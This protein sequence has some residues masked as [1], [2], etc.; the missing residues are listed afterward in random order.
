MKTTITV[1]GAILLLAG[2]ANRPAVPSG[3]PTTVAPIESP[4]ARPSLQSPIAADLQDPQLTV[5]RA[6]DYF[7]EEITGQVLGQVWREH[8]ESS[9]ISNPSGSGLFA[10]ERPFE[11]G[12]AECEYYPGGW[13][14]ASR[15][16]LSRAEQVALIETAFGADGFSIRTIDGRTVFR[17]LCRDNQADCRPA[18]AISAFPHFVLIVPD[19]ASVPLRA[20]AA[21]VIR[22]IDG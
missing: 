11:F 1:V 12:W 3:T 22:R 21:A 18:I 19:D 6:C 20:A 8:F 13:L 10:D 14:L 16:A 7:P 2:C 17:R 4:T 9:A 15:R 5:I